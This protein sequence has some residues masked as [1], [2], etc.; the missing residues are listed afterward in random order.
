MNITVNIVALNTSSQKCEGTKEGER[1]L[2]DRLTT[3]GTETTAL[4]GR[5]EAP[6]TQVRVSTLPDPQEARFFSI[7]F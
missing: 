5:M 7:P 2:V 6:D 1:A 4:T 3:C